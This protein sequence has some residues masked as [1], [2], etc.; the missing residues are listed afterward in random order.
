LAKGAR[1]E[2]QMAVGTY[3]KAALSI[4][5]FLAAVS[6]ATA[7]AA[8]QATEPN[9]GDGA[10][11][12]ALN[13]LLSW[14]P[15]YDADEHDVYFGTDFDDVNTAVF[16]I[17]N[18]SPVF[19]NI[20]SEPNILVTG[21]ALNTTYYWR[22]DEVHVHIPLPES[23]GIFKGD[24]WSFTTAGGEAQCDYPADGEVI[25][26]DAM[27]Y[28][29]DVYI[30]TKLIFIP[31]ATAVEHTGYFSEDY[32]DVA[33]RVQDANLG[34]PPYGSIQGWEYTF[35]AGNP[36]VPPADDTLVRGTKYYW[37]VD[38][39]DAQGNTF[40]GEIWEF[41]VRGLEA[42]EP[43]PP[44]DAVDVETT[45][46]LSWLEGYIDTQG[47]AVFFGTSW[48]DVNDAFYSP[49]N[50]PPE[51]LATTTEPNI[52]VTG[53]EFNTKYYWRIDEC[54]A[55]CPMRLRRVFIYPIVTWP[56]RMAAATAKRRL[57]SSTT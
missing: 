30:W 12:V 48:D 35:F 37:T 10:T 26:G 36:Q 14:L 5:I 16:D 44:N 27:E 46:L 56:I 55:R 33:G 28:L 4:S 2:N 31:G 57:I 43:S 51:L 6:G 32:N 53:L 49:I 8:T 45:V 22:V 19:L 9:P 1:R 54:T 29:G 42:F 23:F 52:L 11:D 50:P 7:S 25:S 18:P 24:V 38:E 13:V 20:V 21:L 34:H 40:A 41:A 3:F 15:G 39:T 17:F 47:Y